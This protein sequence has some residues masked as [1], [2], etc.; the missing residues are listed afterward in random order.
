LTSSEVSRAKQ[1]FLEALE[2]SEAERAGWLARLAQDDPTLERAVRALLDAHSGAAAATLERRAA[3][4]EAIRPVARVAGQRLGEHELIEEIGSGAHGVVWRARQLALGRIVALKVLRSG[5]LAGAKELERLRAEAA[6]VARLDHPHIVPVHEVGEHEGYAFFSMKWIEGGTLADRLGEPW[7]ARKAALLLVGVARAVHHAHQRGLLHRD[8]KPSN[9]LLD[10]EGRPHVADFGIA[11]QLDEGGSAT[12]TRALAGT[13]AYMAPEQ[14][15]GGELT[16]ATDVW[17]LGCIL[18]ELLAGRAAFTGE[19]VTEIL[20]KI[21]HEPP[22]SLR[23]LRPDVPRDLETIVLACLQKDPA[24]RYHSA[25]ALADDLERWL[26]HEPIAAR[27]TNTLDRL[28]LFC[29]RSPLA[30]SLI[31]IAVGLVLLL[32]IVASYASVELGARLRDS[33]LGQARATRLSGAT[34]AR[35]GALELLTRAAAIR[36]GEDLR[37]EAIACLALTDVVLERTLPRG[38]GVDTML[39]PDPALERVAAVDAD[40]L[41]I[42]DA[43]GAV[44]RVLWPHGDGGLVRWSSGGRWLLSRHHPAGSPESDARIRIWDPATGAELHA[45]ADVLSHRAG[46]F[47]PDERS[48][49]YSTLG[50]ELALVE[51]PSGD[52][53]ARIELGARARSLRYSPDGS[54]LA[55]ALV[56]E[57]PRLEIRDAASGALLGT[58]PLP[59]DPYDVCWTGDG[60]GFAVGCADFT[61]RIFDTEASEPRVICRGHSAEVVEI[62]ACPGTTLLTSYSWDETTRLWDAT[63][64]RELR[65]ASARTLGFSA[66]GRRLGLTDAHSWSV[67]R[68]EHGDFLRML[69]AHT[70]KSPAD[71]AFAPDGRA[72]ASGGGDGVYLW[73]GD[74]GSLPRPLHAHHTRAVG[75]VDGGRALLSSGDTGLFRTALEPRGEPQQ[76][77]TDKLWGLGITAD[78]RTVAVQSGAAVVLLDPDRPDTVRTL[79]GA[80]GMEYLTLSA[81]GARVAAGNWH[82]RGVRVW[83]AGSD[84]PLVLVSDLTNVSTALSPDGELLATSTSERIELWRA[85]TGEHLHAHERRRAFGN[86]PAPLAFSPDGTLLAFALSNEIVRLIDVR[87]YATRA[88]LEPPQLEAVLGLAF[89]PDGKLLGAACGTNHVQLWDLAAIDARLEELGLR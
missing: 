81:D 10:A 87:T 71:L 88:T 43:G 8:L 22:A 55:V 35:A 59:V 78:E 66:D 19:S 68:V 51:L 42:L 16:V 83:S 61:I 58:A 44:Q 65:R 45:L 4:L 7:S 5:F 60:R 84:E 46:D 63:T 1:R 49:A 28:V 27:R 76:L 31:G 6:A 86:S 57:T 32:A 37:D 80:E 3:A 64:G 47:A 17:A 89:T 26:A 9:V 50:A 85:A 82:G 13:P 30:A 12:T 21:R 74:P 36:P 25:D 34:G 14:A 2:L 70:G 15:E 40:G 23:A 54:R 62:H 11:K 53:R 79:P 77:L 41:R 33:Y 48:L 24:R 67:W 73:D 39:T 69:Q 72:L 29:R 20:R 18:H 75:F 38:D 56:G 52:T